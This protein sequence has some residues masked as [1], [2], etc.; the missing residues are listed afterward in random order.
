[1][2]IFEVSSDIRNVQLLSIDKKFIMES[3]ILEFDGESKMTKWRL[4]D[5][6]FIF[7]IYNPKSSPKNFF[8]ISEVLCCDQYSLE[9][10]RTVFEIAGE[11]LPAKVERQDDLYFLNVLQIKN[12]LDFENTVWD[13]YDNGTRGRILKPAFHKDRVI[14]ESSIFKTPDTAHFIYCFADVFDREDEFYHIYHDNNLTGL[15]F[16][17]IL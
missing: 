14:N 9:I 11:I 3:D 7:Y 1:M 17:E 4:M 6:D 12:A 10:C 2:R 13:Y 16:T 8:H 15:I 5:K